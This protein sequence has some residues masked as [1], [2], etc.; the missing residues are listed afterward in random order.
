MDQ[1][2]TAQR[3]TDGAESTH[4][5]GGDHCGPPMAAA[6]YEPDLERLGAERL[7]GAQMPPRCRMMRLFVAPMQS[8]HDR[9]IIKLCSRTARHCRVVRA[10]CSGC[11]GIMR[12][13]M[14]MHKTL[15]DLQA[16]T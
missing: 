15:C 8:G 9:C 13:V 16:L 1:A 11:L 10:S 7:P 2:Q 6:C 14:Y 4:Q 5:R 3:K 12:V